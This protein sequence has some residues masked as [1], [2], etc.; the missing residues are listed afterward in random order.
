MNGKKSTA[1]RL[2]VIENEL[3]HIKETLKQIAE[4][5][6]THIYEELDK[7]SMACVTMEDD[8]ANIKSNRENVAEIKKDVDIIKNN[9]KSKLTGRDKAAIIGSLIIAVGGI[10]VAVIGVLT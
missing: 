4:N 2:A 5:H 8:K 10:I 7:I 3:L 1:E 6:L 9:M